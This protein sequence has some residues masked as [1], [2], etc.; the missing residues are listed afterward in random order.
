MVFD[1]SD[2][3][4]DWDTITLTVTASSAS[5]ILEFG[6]FNNDPIFWNQ[7]DNISLEFLRGPNDPGDPELPEPASLLL[8]AGGLAALRLARR[9]PRA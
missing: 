6:N 7:L 8:L 3:A 4:A 9:R 5:T 1:E 2:I